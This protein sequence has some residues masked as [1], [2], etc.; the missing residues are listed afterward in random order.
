M[1]MDIIVG[2]RKPGPRKEI[3]SA[4]QNYERESTSAKKLGVQKYERK[5]LEARKRERKN[6]KF[7]A[8]KKAQKR[9]RERV[10]P[11]A[12]RSKKATAQL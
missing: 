6:A 4:K 12:R 2:V 8:P 10:P 9:Q 1:C 7:K 5:K 3:S 11:G